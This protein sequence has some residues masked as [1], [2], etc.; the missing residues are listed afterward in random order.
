M[1]STLIGADPEFFIQDIASKEIETAIG[2]IP[3][4]KDKQVEVCE[5]GSV[6]R[7]NVLGELNICPAGHPTTFVHNILW[8]LQA[9]DKQ[10]LE[11]KGKKYLIKPSHFYE[12]ES[13]DLLLHPEAQAFGCDED[14]NV[15]HLDTT[16]QINSG[17]AKNLRTAA[18]HI[19]IGFKSTINM[20]EQINTILMCDLFIG[21]PSILLDPDKERRSLYG[22]A[23]CFR[24]K[25]Y[26][27][28][29]RTPSNFWLENKQLMKWIFQAAN[30]AYDYRVTVS[31]HKKKFFE[32]IRKCID[33]HDKDM[34][35]SIIKE[36]EIRMPK[37][38]YFDDLMIDQV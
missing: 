11:P 16:T 25:P 31:S 5:E 18:G 22:K 21:V 27:V 20:K 26:G 28:E 12:G 35:E 33:T 23:G 37:S 34:A 8:T 3:G 15:W 38:S 24:P 9:I 7:D 14:Y 2:I 17:M 36:N 19:H 1:S 30:R 29:Y 4:T 6:H 10:Y 32:E 13:E